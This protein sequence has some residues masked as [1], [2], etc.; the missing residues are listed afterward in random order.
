M[1]HVKCTIIMSNAYS[2]LFYRP[3]AA[4][5]A[6][7]YHPHPHPAPHHVYPT[8][9]LMFSGTAQQP[10]L[11]DYP[12]RHHQ[13]SCAYMST[14]PRLAPPGGDYYMAH[15]HALTGSSPTSTYNDS[16]GAN[17]YTCIGVPV[18]LHGLG[19]AGREGLESRDDGGM[20]SSWGRSYVASS[21]IGS[22]HHHLDSPY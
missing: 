5:S 14:S 19:P 9:P 18:G 3:Y 7:T 10:P 8:R 17:N 11:S 22:E 2:C 6:T 4:P 1:P 21:S 13:Q 20:T 16:A 15:G 12:H